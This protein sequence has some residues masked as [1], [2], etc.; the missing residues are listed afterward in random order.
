[1]NKYSILLLKTIRKLYTKCRNNFGEHCL[2]YETNPDIVSER[3]FNLLS[4]DNPCM[5]ARLGGTELNAMANYLGVSQ[6]RNSYLSFI[7]HRTPA[8]WWESYV[9]NNMM[10]YSGFFPIS[11]AS[12]TKFAKMMI[13]D[14]ALVDILGSWR[15]EEL[16]FQKELRNTYKV[17]LSL[18]EPWWADKPWT[19]ILTG[20]NVLVVHPFADS[21]WQ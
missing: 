11:E 1:M 7:K 12:L 6:Y 4:N 5:I 13:E 15:A 21:I 19:R 3:I 16:Y 8:W 18:L 10:I 14:C 20:K 17:G 2:S 9:K